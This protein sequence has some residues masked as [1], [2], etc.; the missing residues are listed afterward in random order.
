MRPAKECVMEKNVRIAVAAH[1]PFAGSKSLPDGY[2]PLQV[3]SEGKPDLGFTRDN[4]GEHISEKNSSYCELTGL[5]WMWKNLDADIVG[6]CHYRRYFSSR[7]LDRKLRAMLTREQIVKLL[8]KHDVI[9][10]RPVN[11]GRKTV[12]E[13]Y[14]A[15]HYEKDLATTRE[16][17]LALY[18]DYIDSFDSVM[19]SHKT[20]QCNMFIAPKP[21][22]DAYCKWLFDVLGYVEEHTDISG[23]DNVQGRIFG[24]LSERLLSVW[25][26]HHADL[27]ICHKWYASTELT[28]GTVWR[29]IKDK[30]QKAR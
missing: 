10:P 23:Y 26:H 2:F 4:S 29:V 16:A 6:L 24:Y 17:V 13:H 15:F 5:Y 14:C 30:L 11:V 20:Y 9:L 1:K 27:R 22:S 12:G 8:E 21:L 7:P 19:N 25:M 28:M 18:P 3:G